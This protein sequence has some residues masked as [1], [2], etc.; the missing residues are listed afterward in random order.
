MRAHLQQHPSIL[1]TPGACQRALPSTGPASSAREPQPRTPSPQPGALPH[2]YPGGSLTDPEHLRGGGGDEVAEEIEERPAGVPGPEPGLGAE[3]ATLHHRGFLMHAEPQP[4]P[5]VGEMQRARAGSPQPHPPPWDAANRVY[6][7]RA[8][9]R[10]SPRR[11]GAAWERGARA[12]D[13]GLVWGATPSICRFKPFTVPPPLPPWAADPWRKKK[14]GRKAAKEK[15]RKKG[16]KEKSSPGKL[17]FHQGAGMSS[18]SALGSD[19]KKKK[20]VGGR[21]R[22][23]PPRC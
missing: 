13:A 12:A 3:W 2:R 14:K 8:R 19:A 15:S 18:S 16:E 1:P 5:H 10:H 9:R 22:E 21:W 23:G 4:R 20:K 7:R 11:G 6:T 17:R